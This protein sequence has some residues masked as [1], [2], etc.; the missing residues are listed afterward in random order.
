MR[1]KIFSIS[2]LVSVA[3]TL[4]AFSFAAHAQKSNYAAD[5]AELV[6][7]VE[8]GERENGFCATVNFPRRNVIGDFFEYLDDAEE[9]SEYFARSDYP[10]SGGCSYYRILFVSDSGGNKCARTR[11][12]ACFDKGDQSGSCF[13]IDRTWCRQG[14]NWNWNPD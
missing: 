4:G 5:Q 8:A 1:A 6:R 2:C 3:A 10:S 9:G 11:S 14:T 13:K 12:W 7:R